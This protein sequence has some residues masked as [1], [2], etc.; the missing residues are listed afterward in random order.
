[1]SIRRGVISSSSST[2]RIRNIP[3][4]KLLTKPFFLSH[5]P[6]LGHVPTSKPIPLAWDTPHT[7]YLSSRF[8]SQISDK[9][10]GITHGSIKPT[11]QPE[12]E[13]ASL[14]LSLGTQYPWAKSRML[15]ELDKR[16]WM[17]GRHLQNLFCTKLHPG[18]LSK[19][20]PCLITKGCK[21]HRVQVCQIF[22]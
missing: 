3:D 19:I 12:V 15:P 4:Q 2:L 21:A 22:I 17:L 1:M 11:L 9:G 5:W 20:R 8:L 16:K 13:S 14:N 10:V 18:G 7:D 6:E